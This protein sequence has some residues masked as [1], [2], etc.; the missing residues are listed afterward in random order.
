MKK[1]SANY[2]TTYKNYVAAVT[3]VTPITGS[4]NIVYLKDALFASFITYLLPVCLIA[5][6][7]GVYMGITSGFLFIA[8]FDMLSAIAIA[9]VALNK[10]INLLFRKV[11][12]LSVLYC[13]AV[14]LLVALGSFGPGTIY[15]LALS[16]L[17]ALILPHNFTFWPVIINALIC[18]FCGFIIAFKLFSSPLITEYT[19]GVWIAVSSNLIVLSWVTIVIASNTIKTL[20]ETLATEYQLRL[21]LEEVDAEIMLR[22]ELLKE[23]EVHYKSLFV[24]SPTPMWIFE[25]KNLKFLQ[26]NESA[27]REYGYTYEEFMSMTMAD[28]KLEKDMGELLGLL[29]KNSKTGIPMSNITTHRRKNQETFYV[30]AIFN[31]FLY[32]GAEATLVI[33]RDM[34]NQ[35]NF[36][37][38]IEKNNSKLKEIAW[39]QSHVVRAPLARIMGLIDLILINSHQKPDTDTLTYLDQSA[40]EFDEIIKAITAKTEQS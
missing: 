6:I 2:W 3:H 17:V 20:E 22:N 11:F 38:A 9:T 37:K 21:D 14:V 36:T 1:V 34:T 26:V 31:T 13:L 15:L 32:K 35:I 40:K 25:N 33:M 29:Q 4:T 16:I 19:L 23:S 27:I 30:D 5:L 24:L 28:I 8:V 12:V 18:C 39:I 10:H 7:P